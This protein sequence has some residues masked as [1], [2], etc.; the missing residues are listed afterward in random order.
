MT[1]RK[2]KMKR[3][4]RSRNLSWNWPWFLTTVASTEFG[5]SLSRGLLRI[6]CSTPLPLDPNVSQYLLQPLSFSPSPLIFRHFHSM[7]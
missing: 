4:R 3:M 1:M 6:L 7:S 2:M 5:Y